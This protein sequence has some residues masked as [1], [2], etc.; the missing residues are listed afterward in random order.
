MKKL[1]RVLWGSL[2]AFVMCVA[3]CGAD[4]GAVALAGDKNLEKAARAMRQ[5][6]F[7]VAEKIYRGLIEKDPKNIP[8]RLG[9]SYALLKQRNL[10][11]AY[12]HAAR[13]LALEPTSARAHAL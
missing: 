2:A 11:D 13:I 3:M 8:A 5:G 12:D 6:E 1:S 10:R 9:L 4:N 7:E